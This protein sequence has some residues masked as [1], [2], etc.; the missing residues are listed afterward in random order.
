MN[1]V[2]L[3]AVAFGFT[4]LLASLLLGGK[5]TD[6]G[7]GGHDGHDGDDGHDSGGGGFGWAPVTSLRFWVFLLAFGGGT[8]FALTELGQGTAVTA[9]AAGVVGWLSG[10][11]AIAAIAAL[12]RGSVSSEVGATELVGETGRLLLPVAPGRPGKVR[13]DVKGRQEDFIAHAAE[14]GGALA[15]GTVVLIVAE[16]EQGSLLVAKGEM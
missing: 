8:G 10:A 12:R 1:Q 6:S 15:E 9:V 11:I 3:G 13:V 16:G 4:L 5:D 7:D 2:Y 14:D